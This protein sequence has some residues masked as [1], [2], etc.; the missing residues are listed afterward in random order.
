[1]QWYLGR[2]SKDLEKEIGTGRYI[3]LEQGAEVLDIG[4]GDGRDTLYLA[5]QGFRA[6]GVDIGKQPIAKAE[7]T[8]EELGLGD[9]EFLAYDVLQLPKPQARDRVRARFPHVL[10]IPWDHV[11]TAPTPLPC[12][13]R[14]S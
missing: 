1:M 13:S 10:A 8:A 14:S 9:V 12:R 2:P 3:K 5:Q 4:C 6:T 7:T 11:H